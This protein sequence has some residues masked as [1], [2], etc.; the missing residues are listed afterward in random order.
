M[1]KLYVDAD[2]VPKYSGWPIYRD[3]T[4][5]CVRQMVHAIEY[6]YGTKW[7]GDNAGD[8]RW[9]AG[10]QYR[11]AWWKTS[12]L[13]DGHYH[14]LRLPSAMTRL[15]L[16]GIPVREDWSVPDDTIYIVRKLKPYGEELVGTIFHLDRS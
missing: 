10:H 4:L 9:A 8:L 13:A 2:G 1:K 6:E 3:T 14:P 16:N 5:L 7:F 15:C 11:L 12:A